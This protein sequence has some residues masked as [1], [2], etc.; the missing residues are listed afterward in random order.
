MKIVYL[1]IHIHKDPLMF[2]IRRTCM[3]MNDIIMVYTKTKPYRFYCFMSLSLT[4]IQ[5]YYDASLS[6]RPQK[7]ER[8]SYLPY[9][10]FL[11]M[12]ELQTCLPY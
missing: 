7:R 11:S 2:K 3:S 4:N 5:I 10:L 1:F 8:E 12:H 9:S 6:G